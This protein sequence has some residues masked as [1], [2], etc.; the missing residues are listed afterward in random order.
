MLVIEASL[1]YYSKTNNNL[2]NCSLYSDQS[3]CPT[4]L[5]ENGY[6]DCIW[7]EGSCK[8]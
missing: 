1:K 4:S 7:E 3:S 8:R 2:V 6:A 5:D